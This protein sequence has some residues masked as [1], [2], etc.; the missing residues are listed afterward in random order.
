MRHALRKVQGFTRSNDSLP[1]LTTREVGTRAELEVGR[2][3]TARL[4][5]RH[6]YQDGNIVP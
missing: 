6:V 3:A 2:I 1:A 5:S 4:T